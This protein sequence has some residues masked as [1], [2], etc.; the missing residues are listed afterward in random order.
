MGKFWE[1]IDLGDSSFSGS[2]LT[3]WARARHRIKIILVKIFSEQFVN[4]IT[5]RIGET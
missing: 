2:W 4:K 1:K 3:P 5:K